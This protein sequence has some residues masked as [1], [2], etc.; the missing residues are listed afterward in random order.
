MR[1]YEQDMQAR[2]GRGVPVTEANEGARTDSPARKALRVVWR[3]REPL[4]WALLIAVVLT[5][6]WPMLKG[7][8]Y[9][10]AGTAVPG[11][12]IA[13]RTDLDGALAEARATN[14][15]VI[16]DFSA[17]WCPPCVAMKHDVWP[18]PDVA[19]AINAGY[20]AVIV[21]ADRDHG[22]SARYQVDAIPAVLLLDAD[23]RVLKRND[24]YLPTSGML[25]FLSKSAD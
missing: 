3:R 15:R 2:S 17:D 22:L 1:H 18:H 16:V 24:G 7:W 8:Y 14:K 11:S 21:D 20:V 10:A 12:A 19:G 23:G 4:S 9:R 5:V 25:R 6:Q 13:W